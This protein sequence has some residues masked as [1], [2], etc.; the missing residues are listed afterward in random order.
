MRDHGK[1]PEKGAEPAVGSGLTP[2]T[3]R[4][5]EGG[6]DCSAVLG[7]FPPDQRRFS[8]QGLPLKESHASQEQAC[9]SNYCH[10][11]DAG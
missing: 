11:F 4:R 5:Q 3:E 7:Q 6:L 9:I 8:S 1:E 10:S 2:V